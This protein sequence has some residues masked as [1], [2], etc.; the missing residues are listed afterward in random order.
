VKEAVGLVKEDRPGD[1]QFVAYVVGEGD[2]GEWREYLKKQWPHYMVPAYLFQVEG[3]PHKPN[4][5]VNR[6]ELLEWEAQF[7]SEEINKSERT[8]VEA[9]IVSVWGQ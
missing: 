4:G 5:K 8:T 6:K 3:M 1:K 9:L 2:T 7:K